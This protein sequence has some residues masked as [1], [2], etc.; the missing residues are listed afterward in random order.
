MN[1]LLNWFQKKLV[2]PMDKFSQNIWV[3]TIK[4]AILQIVPLTMAGAAFTI[5]TI[6]PELIPACASW[7]PNFWTPYAW[8]LG[9]MSVFV[10]FLVPFTYCEKKRFRKVRIAAGISGLAMF[11]IFINPTIIENGTVGLGDSTLG[12]GGMFVAILAG[13]IATL[14]LGAF[15]K[16]SFF[17]EDSVMPDF[18][19]NMFDMVLPVMICVTL[20][21]ILTDYIGLN[22]FK[23]MQ[24]IFAPIGNFIQT[25]PGYV[26]WALLL[27]FTYSM[28]ISNW[29]YTPIF[30]PLSS[31]AFALNCE[32][33]INGTATNATLN[34][35][36]SSAA[37]CT[38]L[39]SGGEGCTL[40]LCIIGAFLCK[41]EKVKTLSK[42]SLVP[43]VFNI[44]EPVV[45]GLVA[46]NP[47]LM[48]PM[49]LNGVILAT[50]T[51]IFTK[52][53]PFAPIPT[54]EG[55]WFMPFPISTLLCTSGSIK[56]LI[57]CLLQIVL[58][59]LIWYPFVK[60]Y[61][62]KA[63]EEENQKKEA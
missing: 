8:T 46:W 25:L 33:V 39:W 26:L 38:Y 4:D 16:F 2:P 22:V 30:S 55:L 36:G 50:T 40:A 62:K 53:I 41:S 10:S 12:A 49:W 3:Q 34:L 52:V 42:I 6:V 21:W 14:I 29:V 59:G 56:A 15:S 54:V 20:G 18:V 61:D 17:N 31:A 7:W 24:A 1:N 9:I 23:I 44:N 37:Y 5:L 48:I 47:Y 32:M 11:F 27:C 43:G 57:F 63:L 60:M 13:V 28:G 58:S 35:Y 19:Q 45:F 51:Y